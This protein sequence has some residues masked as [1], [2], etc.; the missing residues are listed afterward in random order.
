MDEICCCCWTS[1]D[2]ERVVVDVDEENI[3]K[4]NCVK[5]FI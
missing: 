5:K 1:V 2:D 3:L 4:V